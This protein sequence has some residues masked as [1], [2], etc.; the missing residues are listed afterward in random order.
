[1]GW[2]AYKFTKLD[3]DSRDQTAVQQCLRYTKL[4]KSPRPGPDAIKNGLLRYLPSPLQDTLHNFMILMW[5]TGATPDKWKESEILLLYKKGDPLLLSNYRPIALANAVYKVWTGLL[6]MAMSRYAEHFHI[7]SEG[8]EGFRKDRNTMRS[9]QSLLNVYGDARLSRQNVYAA[10][11]RSAVNI[12]YSN[13]FNTINQD[14]SF[15][16]SMT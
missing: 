14:E 2:E 1:M 15:K 12:D 16:S 10:Y 5:M 6:T 7:L 3:D 8:Q 4:G 11:R 13:A 9:L